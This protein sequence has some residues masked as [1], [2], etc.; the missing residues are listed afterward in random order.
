MMNHKGF[1]RIAYN[2]YF[3]V[4]LFT[5]ISLL[6]LL[7]IF[8]STNAQTDSTLK[9]FQFPADK[10]PRIDGNTDDWA[11]VPAEYIIGNSQLRDDEKKHA[12]LD[13]NN[14]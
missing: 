10:I 4:N 8:P 12:T 7:I 11:M 14:L 2:K 6:F 3:S 9:I 5:L 13:T 1:L